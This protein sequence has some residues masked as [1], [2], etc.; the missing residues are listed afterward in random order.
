[1]GLQEI[2]Q[3]DILNVGMCLPSNSVKVIQMVNSSKDERKNKVIKGH[4]LVVVKLKYLATDDKKL[5]GEIEC[6]IPYEQLEDSYQQNVTE[7]LH[8][9]LDKVAKQTLS[10]GKS[11]GRN[12][13]VLVSSHKTSDDIPILSLRPSFLALS[14]K[15]KDTNEKRKRNIIPSTPSD[16]YIGAKVTGFVTNIYQ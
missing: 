8:L 1:M 12:A 2:Q 11:I 6:R 3:T 14:R 10:V 16:L 7:D 4:A 9:I 5:K 15:K 13:V